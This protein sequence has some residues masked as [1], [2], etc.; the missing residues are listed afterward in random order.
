VSIGKIR[1][2]LY[3]S[4]RFLGDV[5]AVIKGHILRR[6]ERRVAGRW[7]ARLLGRLFRSRA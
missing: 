1:S 5:N 7:T 2:S 4:A 3:R 6:L